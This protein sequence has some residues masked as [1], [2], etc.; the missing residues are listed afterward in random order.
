MKKI[1]IDHVYL[2]KEEE[3]V[4]DSK[5][6][7]EEVVKH[8]QSIAGSQNKEKDIPENWKDDYQ[9]K[10]NIDENVYK[11]LMDIPKLEEIKITINNLAKEKA[12]GPSEI[13]YELFKL[14]LDDYIEKLRQL[15]GLIFNQQEIPVEWKNTYIYPILKPKPWGSRLINT[16]PITLLDTARSKLMMSILTQRLMKIFVEFKGIS[17][18]DCLVIQRL[19]RYEF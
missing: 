19:N 12:A 14:A 11:N 3:I 13:T 9:V 2:E 16:R 18:P 17:S 8:F 5:R 1:I 6:I 4:V 10:E 15:I 7:K